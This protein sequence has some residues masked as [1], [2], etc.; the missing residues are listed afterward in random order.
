[1][2]VADATEAAPPRAE[3]KAPRHEC[4]RCWL[5]APRLA[6]R[7]R[8]LVEQCAYARN[9]LS[10][11]RGQLCTENHQTGV[12]CAIAA[13]ACLA[14]TDSHQGLHCS[15]I[16]P[17]CYDQSNHN[18]QSQ[19]FTCRRFA[20]PFY[21]LSPYYHVYATPTSWEQLRQA[22]TVTLVSTQYSDNTSDYMR[23]LHSAC[24]T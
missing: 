2:T 6:L 15:H 7:T 4:S 20:I 9:A 23:L 18:M 16:K 10:Y 11:M 5:W 13:H 1:M 14:Y 17:L 3:A 12:I 8:L 22:L 24:M 21:L 19:S